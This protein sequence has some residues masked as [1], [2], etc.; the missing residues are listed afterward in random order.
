MTFQEIKGRQIALLDEI[1]ELRTGHTQRCDG[2]HVCERVYQLG[3]EY[4]QLALQIRRARHPIYQQAQAI[5]AKGQDATKSE[6]EF[7]LTKA[8][9][10]KKETAKALGIS[11]ERFRRLYL[12]W[13]IGKI[14]VRR[15]S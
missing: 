8:C 15:A 3:Q 13:G 1:A 10:T 9:M 7:L 12:A 2:C 11:Q 6:I 5:L 14:Y 4:E